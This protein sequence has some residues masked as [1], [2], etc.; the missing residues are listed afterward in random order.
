M[1]RALQLIYPSRCITCGDLVEGDFSL[2]GTC[3]RDTGFVTGPGC[4]KCGTPL[5]GEEVEES[6]LCDSCISIARPWSRGRTVFL[7]SENG[8]KIVLALKHGD[9][10]DLV[11]PAAAW[12]AKSAGPLLSENTLIVPVPLHWTRLLKRRYNQSALLARGISKTTGHQYCPDL[13][14]RKKRT[15]SL[16]GMNLGKRF[17]TL[18]NV[19][20]FNPRYRTMIGKH[21]VLLVDDVMTSGATL[22]AC[23]DTCLAAG[24]KS[25]DI[26][27]LARVAKTA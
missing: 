15:K 21:R 13:L 22:A 26:V 16:E 9:R 1:Q 2:C 25:V 27:T 24:A 14:I 19:I 20:T 7:Y 23:T 3:W 5:P 17:E 6:D 18:A 4:S 8:R 12:L 10:L 11:K